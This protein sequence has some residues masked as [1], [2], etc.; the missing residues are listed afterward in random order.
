[1]KTIALTKGLVTVVDSKYY[2]LL[3]KHKWHAVKLRYMYYAARRLKKHEGSGTV[4]MHKVVLEYKLN[5]KLLKVEHP[6]HRNR[7]SLDNR[8]RNIRLSSN[9]Q[10]RCNTGKQRNN[11]SGY[12]GVSWSNVMQAW[13]AQIMVDGKYVSLGYRKKKKEAALLYIKAAKKYHKQFACY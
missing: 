3:S 6:D 1:M 8:T 11:T 4:L 10:N 7:D 13:R 2:K 12:K 9:G 5:R